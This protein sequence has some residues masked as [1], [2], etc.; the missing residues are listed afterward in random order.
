MVSFT[1]PAA[2]VAAVQAVARAVSFSN[3]VGESIAQRTIRFELVD[4]D[5]GNDRATAVTN[6]SLT[7]VNDTP[8]V[9]DVTANAQEDGTAITASFDGDDVDNDDGPATLVYAIVSQPAE[10]TAVYNGD[11]TFTF[12]PGTAFQ[13][14]GVGESRAATFQYKATDSHGADSNPATVRVF[15]QGTND[16]PVATE[17]R[18]AAARNSVL[19]VGAPGVLGNDRD[20]DGDLLTATL[21][22]GPASGTL[23]LRADGSFTYTPVTDFTGNVSFTYKS[24]DGRADSNTVTVTLA[25]TIAPVA[26]D[27]SVIT[28]QDR[29]TPIAVL[30][31]DTDPDG[32]LNPGSIIIVTPPTN[33]TAIANS[34]GTITYTPTPGFLGGDG[35]SYTVAD[36]VGVRSNVATVAIQVNVPHPWM[37]PEESLDVNA[38]GFITSMDALLIINR[39]NTVGPQR[40][41]NPP[42]PEF[43]P[44]PY[45]DANG[46]EFLTSA[47][48]LVIIN[49]LN[50]PPAAEGE[51]SGAPTAE[52]FAEGEFWAPSS[53]L[54]TE[55]RP[56]GEDRN[57]AMSEEDESAENDPD[58]ARALLTLR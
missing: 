20:V 11:G 49:Y 38:D 6:V 40:L 15:V 25:V 46:D 10:G 14:L 23:D 32:S 30:V 7:P 53:R 41:P 51:A 22:S 35:L 33:G 39:L 52:A 42:E 37:N 57:R 31:N 43:A 27:D 1:T 16:V 58:L 2:T 28:V 55:S 19:V 44:P 26:N 34:D 4:G 24:N 45:Y 50:N 5:G 47:D 48:A 21:V 36:N 13:D 54:M 18:F 8:F 56:A 17:D 12:S 29:I 3:N 9:R